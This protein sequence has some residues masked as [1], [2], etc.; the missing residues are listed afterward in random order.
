MI[1]K[2]LH[3]ITRKFDR[4][5]SSKFNLEE[6]ATAMS[7]PVVSDGISDGKN[8]NSLIISLINIERDT[9]MGINF[10]PR[11]MANDRY[12]SARPALS[13]NLYVLVSTNFADKNY[14]EALK[15]LSA[16]LEMVQLNDLLTVHNTPELAPDISKL[17][18]ELENINFNELSNI[19]SVMG[20]S[21]QPSLLLK[22]R[23]LTID[24]HEIESIQQ[25]TEGVKLQI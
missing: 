6:K 3:I 2:T 13:L 17:H 20:G 7:S 19:W 1:Y 12:S 23:M 11:N 15:Y 22:V 9:T 18:L 16:A 24:K 4:Y 25:Q 8:V 14:D 21:Y 5:L 10:K